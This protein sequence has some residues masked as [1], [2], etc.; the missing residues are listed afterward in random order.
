M[1]PLISYKHDQLI[2]TYVLKINPSNNM[3]SAY[4]LTEWALQIGTFQ[5]V[6]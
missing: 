2:A 4:I 5:H 3:I 6:D 1:G